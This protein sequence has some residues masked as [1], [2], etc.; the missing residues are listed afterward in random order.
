[1][2]GKSILDGRASQAYESCHADQCERVATKAVALTLVNEH[3][4]DVEIVPLCKSCHKTAQKNAQI[5][6]LAEPRA[7]RLTKSVAQA[8]RDQ[9]SPTKKAAPI[10]PHKGNAQRLRGERPVNS[11]RPHLVGKA[12]ESMTRN[13]TININRLDPERS[14]GANVGVFD[15]SDNPI[16]QA[17]EAR[18]REVANRRRTPE[19]KEDIINEA[20]KGLKNGK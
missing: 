17:F 1:M 16:V 3:G 8:M 18:H 20:R 6:G 19:Q 13:H 9:D 4:A 2:A 15:K 7:T 5:R 14:I 12:P 10:N 11:S